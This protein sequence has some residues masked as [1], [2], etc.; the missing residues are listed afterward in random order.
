VPTGALTSRY[1]ACFRFP[2][3]PEDNTQVD[4]EAERLAPLHVV[5][6][7]ARCVLPV[8]DS[9]T[10]VAVGRVPTAYRH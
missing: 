10:E 5:A 9:G 1:V 2:G 4:L 3:E 8:M 7:L 6:V